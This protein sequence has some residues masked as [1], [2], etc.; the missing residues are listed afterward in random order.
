MNFLS[1]FALTAVKIFHFKLLDCYTGSQFIPVIDCWSFYKSKINKVVVV[2]AV[3]IIIM[4]IIKSGSG[5][6]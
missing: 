2:L 6:I 4:I 1:F 3:I 5:K